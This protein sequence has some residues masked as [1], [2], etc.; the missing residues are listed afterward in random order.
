M[1]KEDGLLF[2]RAIGR[3]FRDH[4]RRLLDEHHPLRTVIEA[5]LGLH[6]RVG[7]EQEKLDRQVRQ[8]AKL[9]DTTRRLMTVPGVGPVTALAFRHTVDDP[10]RFGSASS[11]GAYLGLTP[12]RKQSGQLD[13]IG[14]VSKWGDRLLRTYLF[15]AASVVIHRTKRWSALKAWGIRL[16]KRIGV[17]KAKVAVARKIAVILHCIWADGTEFEWGRQKSA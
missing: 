11:V 5:L 9:D 14:R 7:A 13:V 15:E 3:A 12:R 16:M 2:A 6:D 10:R 17:K 4:V 1:L 8:L